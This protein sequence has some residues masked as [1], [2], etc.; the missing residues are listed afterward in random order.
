MHKKQE[1]RRRREVGVRRRKR[2][3]L[4]TRERKKYWNG[5]RNRKQSG[6]K[7]DDVLAYYMLLC[8]IRGTGELRVHSFAHH[9]RRE[10]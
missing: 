2:Q 5:T 1:R 4:E 9:T 6:E 8:K 3:N 10:S 7:R